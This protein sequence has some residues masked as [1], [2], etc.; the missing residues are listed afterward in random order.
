MIAIEFILFICLVVVT[1][2]IIIKHIKE[3]TQRRID[4]ENG[5]E[6]QQFPGL[7]GT[8]TTAICTELWSTAI[9]KPRIFLNLDAFSVLLNELHNITA[10]F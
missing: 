4:S 1:V 10:S 3:E 6:P 5:T 2:P 9:L 8:E 7:N